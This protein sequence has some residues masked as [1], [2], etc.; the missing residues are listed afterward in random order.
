MEVIMRHYLTRLALT[1]LL[2]AGAIAG[3]AKAQALYGSIVGNVTDPQGGVLQ[4]VSVTITN[5]GTGLKLEATTDDTG[6]YVFRNLLPGTYNM[7]LSHSGFKEMQQSDITVTAG[8]P[9]RVDAALQIGA[10]QETVTV[11]A[12]AA[13][14]RTEKSDISSE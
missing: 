8:N 6:T 11:T 5:T 9:K 1:A 13:T 10:A 4:G 12:E 14:L 3:T 2:A 7:T